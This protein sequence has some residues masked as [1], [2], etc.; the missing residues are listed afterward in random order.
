MGQIPI[1]SS[2]CE[3]ADNGS[4]VALEDS[5][6]GM[7]F[8]HAARELIEAVDDRNANLPPTQKVNVK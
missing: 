1:E 5:I 7:A 2:I 3:H 6:S 4:P 8:I